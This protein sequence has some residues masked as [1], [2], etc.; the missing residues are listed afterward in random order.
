MSEIDPAL[1]P[2]KGHM[3]TIACCLGCGV[4]YWPKRRNNVYCGH[5]CQMR[6]YRARLKG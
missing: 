3:V 4:F 2:R 1:L 5:A 6:A